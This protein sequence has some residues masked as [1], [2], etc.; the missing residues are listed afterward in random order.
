MFEAFEAS[1]DLAALLIDADI[2]RDCYFFAVA[3][4]RDHRLGIH[5]CDLITQVVAVTGLKAIT[6]L[7]R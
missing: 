1:L 3:P 6:A 7:A 2:V 5:G 4:R